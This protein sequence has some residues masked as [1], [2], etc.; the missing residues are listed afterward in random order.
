MAAHPQIID[1]NEARRAASARAHIAQGD[2]AGSEA[3][4]V[5]GLRNGDAWAE[6]ALL[7]HYT[8]HVERLFTRMLGMHADIEELV[9]EVF[10]R[11]FFRVEELR[12][13]GALRAW[14]S[15]IAV[16]VAREAIRSKRRRRWLVFLAPEEVPEIAALSASPEARAALS[17]FYAIVDGFDPDVRIAFTLRFVEGMGLSEVADICRVSLATIKRRLKTGETQFV[18]RAKNNDALADWLT[19]GTRWHR[20]EA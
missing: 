10:V 6:R 17:A 13:V 11:A 20:A 4:L 3:D 9:Q 19:E 8:D 2:V 12:N 1:I 5:R 18:A 15:S 14:L 7:A 16:F